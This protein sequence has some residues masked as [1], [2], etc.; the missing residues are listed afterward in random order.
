MLAPR[1]VP[2]DEFLS[3][4]ERTAMLDT[5]SFETGELAG[6]ATAIVPKAP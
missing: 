2:A 6:G 4:F 1:P 3:H 5:T